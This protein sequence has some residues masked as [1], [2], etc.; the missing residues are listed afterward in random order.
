[1]SAIIVDVGGT[2]WPENRTL[3]QDAE[4]QALARLRRA[5]PGWESAALQKLVRLSLPEFDAGPE[6]DTDGVI[7]AL[8]QAVGLSVDRGQA[9][10]IRRALCIPAA[11]NLQLFP[12][13]ADL[14]RS[15]RAAGYQVVV[16][17]NAITRDSRQ[18]FEDFRDQGIA[19]YI[20]AV[21]TSIEVGYLKPHPA[22]FMAALAA[23]GALPGESA[24]IGNSE[25]NDIAP[26]KALGMFTL[27]VCIEEPLA[28]SSAADAV[29]DSL[30][31]AARAII[32]W[33]LVLCSAAGS[34]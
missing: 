31:D 12:G 11:G 27:R 14:L 8:A 10:L 2:L 9:T 3:P 23:A 28:R 17:S 5:L 7:C 6:Q 30:E 19:D 18:Y 13:A 29:V 4:A 25:V 22:M 21:V 32:R 15:I 34:S 24:M 16:L 26:A 33:G 20:D 1:M